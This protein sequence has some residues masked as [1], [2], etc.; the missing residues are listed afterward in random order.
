MRPIGRIRRLNRR[1]FRRTIRK[2]MRGSVQ[3]TTRSNFRGWLATW[4]QDR[5]RER[6]QPATA[7]TPNAPEIVGGYFE[8]D[9][10]LP[11]YAD[12][13]IEFMFDDPNFPPASVEVYVSRDMGP[14]VLLATVGSSNSYFTYHEATTNEADF[15]FKVRY[16]NGA[17]TGPFSNVFRVSVSL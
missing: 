5:R 11:G 1:T 16:V 9:A 13:T 4:L 14:Y 12:V 7:P 6:R 15:D 2:A 17:V 10:S 3:R 8:W